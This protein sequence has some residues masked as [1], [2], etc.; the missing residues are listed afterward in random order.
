MAKHWKGYDPLVKA[1]DT[2]RNPESP[3]SK[4]YRADLPD[5]GRRLGLKIKQT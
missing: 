5:M 1:L 3:T 4:L 2:D